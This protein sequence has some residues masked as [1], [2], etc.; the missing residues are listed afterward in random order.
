MT[1]ID[2]LFLKFCLK[3]NENSNNTFKGILKNRKKCDHK[4]ERI[5]HFL[6][7]L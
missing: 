1:K 2:K 5:L 4:F 7:K 3:I 6:T